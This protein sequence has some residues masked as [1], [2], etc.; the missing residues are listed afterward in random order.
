MEKTN[1][2]KEHTLP[3]QSRRSSRLPFDLALP[4][5]AAP[6]FLLSGPELVIAGAKAGI[7]ATLPALNARSSELF[8]QWLAQVT[9]EIARHKAAHPD[10]LT[11]P[12]AVNLVTHRSNERL[13]ADLAVVVKYKVPIVF[14]AVGDPKSVNEAVHSY[15]GLV[16]ADVASIRHARRAIDGG[17]DGLVLLCAGA[18]GNCGKLNPFAFVPAV[19]QFWDGPI[20][21]AGAIGDGRAIAAMQMLGADLA[22][23]G[24]RFIATYESLASEQYREMLVTSDADDV[25]LTDE[26]T[27]IPA[28]LLRSSLVKCGFAPDGTRNGTGI[29][30]NKEVEVFKRWKDIWSAGQGVGA[31]DRICSV[32]EVIIQLKNEYQLHC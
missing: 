27:G 24:T 28:N 31:T 30:V 14:T 29:D 16:F 10:Q 20:A 19:R 8:D 3:A 12:L 4:V 26:V 25:V 11:G 7:V 6:M 15:G 2:I 9:T 1:L 21:L 23:M 17:V 5:V 18:G 32:A 13:E 22:Y